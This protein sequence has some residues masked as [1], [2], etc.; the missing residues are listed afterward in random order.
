[1]KTWWLNASLRDKQLASLGIGCVVLFLIYE[2][3]F[4]PLINTVDSMRQRIHTNQ[5]LLAW[6]QESNKRIQSLEKSQQPATPKSSASLL[7]TI[8]NN[9]N[10]QAIGK[11]IYQLQQA[12]NDAI[13]V[14][15]QKVNFDALSKWLIAVCQEQGLIITE[16]NVTPGAAPGIV[17]ADLKLQAG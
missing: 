17:D 12:E 5:T 1:M 3:T 2:L 6:M 4:A 16:M 13:Q 15:L 9:V 10:N 11:N 14:R 7:S 8:Q